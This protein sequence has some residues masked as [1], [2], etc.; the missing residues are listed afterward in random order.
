MSPDRGKSGRP[1]P[2]LLELIPTAG[3]RAP[4]YVAFLWLLHTV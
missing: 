3:C 2:I 1:I 4:S